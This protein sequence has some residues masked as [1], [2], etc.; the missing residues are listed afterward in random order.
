M[1][2]LM[3]SIFRFLK[4]MDCLDE[5]NI[6]LCL[7]ITLLF[8]SLVKIILESYRTHQNATLE[9]STDYTSIEVVE[10][11]ELGRRDC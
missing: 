1:C 5:L 8:K 7:I 3:L 10:D 4:S 2:Y 6:L 11:S 9:N